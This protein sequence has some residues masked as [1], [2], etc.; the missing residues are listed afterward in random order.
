[1]GALTSKPFAFNAR[2]WELKSFD[3]IDLNDSVGSNIRIDVR[4]TNIFRI[5]PRANEELNED[6]ITD[7]VRFSYDGLSYQ[8]LNSP[9][10]R[11]SRANTFSK[12]GWSKLFNILKS[13]IP[14]S[15]SPLDILLGNQTSF[16]S[17]ALIKH[18]LS[19]SNSKVHNYSSYVNNL[20]SQSNYLFNSSTNYFGKADFFLLLGTN[21][22]FDAPAINLKIK[23]SIR[24][25]PDTKVF[26]S[27]STNASSFTYPVV[28][29]GAIYDFWNKFARGR[30]K[31]CRLFYNAKHPYLILGQKASNLSNSLLKLA[32]SNCGLG[33]L[34]SRLNRWNGLN[35]LPLAAASNAINDLNFG[36][37]RS[38]LNLNN[39]KF[40]Y[41]LGNDNT[42]FISNNYSFVV[43]QGYHGDWG[44]SNSNLVIPTLHPYESPESTYANIYGK[45]QSV[46]QVQTVDKSLVSDLEF[47]KYLAHFTGFSIS[48]KSS[49]TELKFLRVKDY[50]FRGYGSILFGIAAGSRYV[51]N[52]W[53][54]SNPLNVQ[55]IYNYVNRKKR[56]IK[57]FES[58][59]TN[60]NYLLSVNLKLNKDCLNTEAQ[61]FY[62]ADPLLRSSHIMALAHSRFKDTSSFYS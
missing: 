3:S 53:F 13:Y 48:S 43:Y 33:N 56:R 35:F 9:L 30:H 31:L 17:M 42:R 51:S 32:G 27:G 22:R 58:L 54:V 50:T 18:F 45:L 19:I 49:L 6:W 29:L 7:K 20:D 24:N 11:I 61:P 23:K 21:L 62:T 40:L 47:L 10:F 46:K 55:Y 37:Y 39:S 41:I 52:S 5:L 15:E 28:N 36:A 25:N 34:S 14:F 57:L 26:V 4:G 2:P 60:L 12:I 16:E 8:R 38:N 44:A 1:M 59:Y